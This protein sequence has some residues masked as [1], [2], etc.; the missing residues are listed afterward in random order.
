MPAGRWGSGDEW[1]DEG[2]DAPAGATSDEELAHELALAAALDRSRTDLSP[3][4]ETATRM[5]GDFFARLEAEW[6]AGPETEAEQTTR[7]APIADVPIAPVSLPVAVGSAPVGSTTET[8][9]LTADLRPDGPEGATRTSATGTRTLDSASPNGSDG[10][11]TRKR[12]GGNK[13]VLPTDHPDN[14]GRATG[15]RGPGGRRPSLRRRVAVVGGAAM[16]AVVAL[17][18]GG[19]LLSRNAL[20]GDS[21]YAMKLMAEGTGSAFTWGDSAKAQRQLELA[22]TRL[23]EVQD[24]R[25]RGQ[26]ADSADVEKAM[27]AFD[28]AASEG[29]RIMLAGAQPASDASL[30]DLGSWAR[31]QSQRIAGMETAGAPLP[32]ASRSKTLMN[33]LADRAEA[34]QA[35]STCTEVSSGVDDLGPIPATGTCVPAAST[36]TRGGSPSNHAG[37]TARSGQPGATGTTSNPTGTTPPATGSTDPSATATPGQTEGGILPNLVGGE[38]SGTTT[39]NGSSSGSSGPSSTQKKDSLLPPVSIPPLLPGLP[40]ITIG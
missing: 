30:G 21:L 12:R 1:W 10:G 32:G 26:Q 25:S 38:Q 15:S 11:V 28:S 6:G 13:H 20:P 40:S 31:A 14:P 5:R 17:A 34:L 16:L 2:F 4:E 37:D 33:R 23:Q 7:M 22:A 18:G 9:D 3:D 35:R 8:T 24:L 36:T 19:A 39:P 27:A 29:S